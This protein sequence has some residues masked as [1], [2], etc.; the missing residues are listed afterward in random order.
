MKGQSLKYVT[1][2]LERNFLLYKYTKRTIKNV[3]GK[4]K[5]MFA[6]R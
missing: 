2:A 3:K 5:K 6:T 4:L 1:K